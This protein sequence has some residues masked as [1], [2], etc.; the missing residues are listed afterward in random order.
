MHWR[1]SNKNT[2]INF[3]IAISLLLVFSIGGFSAIRAYELKLL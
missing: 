2:Y 1:M 3:A